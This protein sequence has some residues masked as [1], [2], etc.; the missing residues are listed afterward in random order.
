MIALPARNKPRNTAP[1]EVGLQ[2]PLL[3]ATPTKTKINKTACTARLCWGAV[4][5]DIRPLGH[6]S[7]PVSSRKTWNRATP[8]PATASGKAKRLSTPRWLGPVM[9][10]IPKTATT[11]M[12]K[13]RWYKQSG[14]ALSP[15]PTLNHRLPISART[16]ITSEGSTGRSVLAFDEICHR[17]GAGVRETDML[18]LLCFLLPNRVKL[19]GSSESR[20]L[21]FH[22][23]YRKQPGRIIAVAA[24]VCHSTPSGR[25]TEDTRW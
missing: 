18:K 13:V 25:T 15:M 2:Q 4:P 3:R 14:H 8:K 10:P 11:P 12:T 1:T 22:C 23:R 17:S 21:R 7:F 9:T 6:S 20:Q 24:D 19:M 16:A 5:M